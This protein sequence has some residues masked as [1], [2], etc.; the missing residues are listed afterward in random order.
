MFYRRDTGTGTQAFGGTANN[1]F[2]VDL[3]EEWARA[4]D[5]QRNTLRANGIYRMPWSMT[6]AATY[7]YGS[8][9]YFPTRWAGDPLGANTGVNRTRPDL[10]LVP[11][12]D[13]K[14]NSIHKVDFRITKEVRLPGDIRVSGIAEVFNV[15]NHANYGNYQALVNTSTFG[16]PVQ[17]SSNTY[18]PRSAQFAFKVSF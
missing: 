11:R 6:V 14:G 2:D 1:P 16:L 9:A 4:Q 13:L 7:A 8:G 18:M 17:N 3:T 15:F 10:T 5:F 12:N